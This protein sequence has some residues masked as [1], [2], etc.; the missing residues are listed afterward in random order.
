[1][2]IS[3]IALLGASLLL[4]ACGKGPDT[5]HVGP[6]GPQGPVG[7]QPLDGP[8]PPNLTVIEDTD[9]MVTKE[10]PFSGFTRVEISDGFNVT[11][12]R[13]EGFRVSTQFEKTAVP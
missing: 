1:M 9:V 12:R 2:I 4:G 8:P 5:G 7:P 3:L 6:A 13:G 11:I 10:Y